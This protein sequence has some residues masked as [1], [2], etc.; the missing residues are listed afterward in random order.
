MKINI[1][2]NLFLKDKNYADDNN[3]GLRVYF[4]DDSEGDD[5]TLQRSEAE[6]WLEKIDPNSNPQDYDTFLDT[7]FDS[8]KKYTTGASFIKEA[9]KLI[10]ATKNGKAYTLDI[11]ELS[12]LKNLGNNSN[13]EGSVQ[14]RDEELTNSGFWAGDTTNLPRVRDAMYAPRDVK[15][16]INGKKSLEQITSYARLDD[17]INA[18]RAELKTQVKNGGM[19]EEKAF[20]IYYNKISDLRNS[21]NKFSQIPVRSWTDAQRSDVVRYNGLPIIVEILPDSTI[22]L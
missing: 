8:G 4:N 20:D 11:A 13:T 18:L 7:I 3:Y 17:T 10:Q 12:Q 5:N 6:A 9:E 2:D 19:T 22:K 15:S 21:T 14:D 1:H 16:I